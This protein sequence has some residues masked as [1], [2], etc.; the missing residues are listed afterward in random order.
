MATLLTR[1]RTLTLHFVIA[2]VLV[3]PLILPHT[4][5]AQKKGFDGIVEHLENKYGAR[6]TRIPFLGVANFFIKIIRP[7]GVKSFKL[8]VFEDFNYAS[9]RSGMSFD[10]DMRSLMPKDWKPFVKVSS[11]AGNREQTFIYVKPDGK[12]LQMM[13]VVLEAREAVV[14][15]VKLNPDA[16]GKFLNDPKVMGVSLA[17]NIRGASRIDPMGGFA[18]NMG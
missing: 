16:V 8:A 14:M 12:D 18:G 3:T 13:T 4:A 17:G 7:A 6:R 9:L 1:Y 15:E 10:D 5:Y 11:R 2:G